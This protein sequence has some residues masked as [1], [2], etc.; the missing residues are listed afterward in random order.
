VFLSLSFNSLLSRGSRDVFT[1]SL[2]R[3]VQELWLIKGLPATTVTGAGII[4]GYGV[5]FYFRQQQESAWSLY[6]SSLNYKHCHS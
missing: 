6:L 5:T 3:S 1:G 4:R 2:S